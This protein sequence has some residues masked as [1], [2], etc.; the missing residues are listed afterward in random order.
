MRGQLSV[1]MFIAMSLALVFFGWLAN[2]AGAWS[3]T[4]ASSSVAAQERMVASSLARLANAACVSSASVEITLP[5][6]SV[7]SQTAPAYSVNA[8]GSAVVVL[9]EGADYSPASVQTVCPVSGVF[10]AQCQGGNAGAAC[11]WNFGGDARISSG[12]CP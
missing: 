3:S 11:V 5:C 10:E 1:E 7:G 12:E 4:Q 6:I 2:F 9:A 8:T